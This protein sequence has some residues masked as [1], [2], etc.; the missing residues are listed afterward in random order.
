MPRCAAADFARRNNASGISTV[1]FTSRYS[2][3]S[4]SH[5]YGRR[6]QRLQ[7]DRKRGTRFN[8]VEERGGRGSGYP[9]RT[10][11]P[12]G[13]PSRRRASA[14]EKPRTSKK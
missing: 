12:G 3:I 13:D 6:R 4:I 5:I 2:P 1:V 10:C 8:A 14:R 7:V 11:S 9:R